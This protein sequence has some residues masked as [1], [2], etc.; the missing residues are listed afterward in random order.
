VEHFMGSDNYI[1]V[2]PSFS[3]GVSRAIDLGGAAQKSSYLV[4]DNPSEADARAI[5][6]DW[7]AVGNEIRDAVAA[8]GAPVVEKEQK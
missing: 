2:M 1:F 7:A 4:S 8:V 3:R 6:S 5:A